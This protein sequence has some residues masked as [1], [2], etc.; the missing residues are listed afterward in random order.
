MLMTPWRWRTLPLVAGGV[1]LALLAATPGAAQDTGTVSGTIIDAS[2][3]VVPGATI[4]LTHEATVSARTM[5]S[6]ERGEFA[7]RAV[8]PGSYTVKVEL[9]GF[10]SF[11]HRNN[12]LNA[13]GRLDWGKLTLEVGTLSEIV[14]VTATGTCVE[15]KN[16]DYNLFN[17]VEFQ[18][19]DRTAR[20]DANG[21]QI[22]P[23]FGTPIGITSPTRPPRVIQ[24]SVRGNF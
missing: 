19:I 22:N 9:T 11:E 3:E 2:G 23:N 4:T 18:D 24:L 15:T 21:A 5:Q 7:F 1:L 10:R 17:Q 12:V 8:T 14:S 20:F 6:D 16:S 13:S